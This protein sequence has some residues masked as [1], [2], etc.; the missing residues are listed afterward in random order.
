VS[1]A[2]LYP[3]AQSSTVG[4]D[5]IWCARVA[6]GFAACCARGARDYQP[7]AEVLPVG[8][9]LP[10]RPRQ[11][12]RL[13]EKLGR[14]KCPIIGAGRGVIGAERKRKWRSWPS[15]RARCRLGPIIVLLGR[16]AAAEIQARHSPATPLSNT[17]TD[18]FPRRPR[19]QS[20]NSFS[21]LKM[22]E[23][24]TLDEVTPHQMKPR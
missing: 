13:L 1:A 23:R 12:N 17:A 20:T 5:A 3:F 16:N 22:P 9:A 6:I 11:V 10:P 7:A 15:G 14:A 24:G 8:E 19:F 18:A 21:G 4:N 2:V